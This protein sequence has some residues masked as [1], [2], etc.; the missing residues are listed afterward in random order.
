MH[1]FIL[2]RT[3][4]KSANFFQHTDRVDTRDA[5]RTGNVNTINRQTDAVQATRSKQSNIV[6]RDS[7]SLIL[8]MCSCE[9]FAELGYPCEK[10]CV[11]VSEMFFGSSLFG[12]TDDRSFCR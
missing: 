2:A 3:V 1:F 12:V 10:E 9:K 7:V 6:V 4:T 8:C 11:L 5:V